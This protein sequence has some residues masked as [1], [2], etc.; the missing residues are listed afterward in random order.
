MSER[1]RAHSLIG[2]VVRRELT[3]H[4]RLLLYELAYLRAFN[5]WEVFLDSIFVRYL[6]GYEFGGLCETPLT[7]FARDLS[8][9]QATLYAGRPY[10]LWHNPQDAIRRANRHF[11][12]NNR[13]STV[14]G[15]ALA[16]LEDFGAIRH[17]IAHDHTDARV[18]FDAACMRLA[19]RHFWGS[20][21]GSFLRAQ[22][23]C[24]T[25]LLPMTWLGRIC[26]D[27]GGL[28]SQLAP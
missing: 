12:I 17:R 28:A 24:G 22:T 1:L 3:D 9:A 11:T 13:L 25:P 15:S 7:A 5:Q 14:I 20:R 26:S 8:T 16:D 6:C 21:P 23:L 27:L 10:L 19:G 18:K 4:R 2:R